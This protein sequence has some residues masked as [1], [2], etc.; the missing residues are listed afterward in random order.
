MVTKAFGLV[1][2]RILKGRPIIWT[3][4]AAVV[5]G[6]LAFGA[7][8]KPIGVTDS[9]PTTTVDGL[10]LQVQSGWRG[11]LSDLN[12][13]TDGALETV[14]VQLGAEPLAA[15][16][17]PS[18]AVLAALPLLSPQTPDAAITPQRAVEINAAIP[19]AR[20]PIEA[21]APFALAGAADARSRAIYCLT[22]A[23]YYEA[24]FEP[25]EGQRAV[26]QVVLNRVR[27]P[28]F[29]KSVCGVVFQGAGKPGCQFTFACDGAMLRPVNQA[30]WKRAGQVAAAALNGQVLSTVGEATHYHTDWVAP[31][32]G[33][34]L[35]KITQIGA[36]IFYRWPGG[37]GL[38]SA[39]YARYAGLE[40]AVFSPS[41]A[42]TEM[43][44]AEDPNLPPEPPHAP[45]DVGGRVILG[46]GWTPSPPVASTGSL[47]RILAEQQAAQ[48]KAAQVEAHPAA[49]TAAPAAAAAA[50]DAAATPKSGG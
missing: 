20:T 31:Y 5:V 47:Q 50:S 3:A 37:A 25:G 35:N 39:F 6:A 48:A 9:R 38:R 8:A 17:P 23:V 41:A 10:V 27:H 16:K 12:R 26:A 40:P 22:A 21:A 34:K 14:L 2:S 42:P 45:D 1:T 44:A 49:A 46:L 30:A 11:A 36:H 7:M 15:A 28:S 24:G 32:W 29:P 43:A 13:A 33:A 4:C 19:F 18:A